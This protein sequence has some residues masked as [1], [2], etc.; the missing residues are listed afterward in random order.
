MKSWEELQRSPESRSVHHGQGL[1]FL[2]RIPSPRSC[3]GFGQYPNMS[4]EMMLL[5][6]HLLVA[7]LSCILGSSVKLML[8]MVWFCLCVLGSNRVFRSLLQREELLQESL[9]L[10]N[11][12]CTRAVSHQLW[13]SGFGE[14]KE[15]CL[16]MFVVTAP[17]LKQST[18]LP[19]GLQSFS[20]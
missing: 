17:L 7:W 6:R 1:P 18:K 15:K 2:G 10:A 5:K 4:E 16:A 14:G 3:L 11:S 19:A 9:S 8:S 12:W 20:S 13:D